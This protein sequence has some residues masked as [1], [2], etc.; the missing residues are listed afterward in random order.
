MSRNYR[1][2]KPSEP[3]GGAGLPRE[4]EFSRQRPQGAQA[5]GHVRD[6]MAPLQLGVRLA[7]QF[8]RAL[9]LTPHGMCQRQIEEAVGRVA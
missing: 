6:A 2:R 5:T 1:L 3:T 8:R 7:R 9:Q 4:A